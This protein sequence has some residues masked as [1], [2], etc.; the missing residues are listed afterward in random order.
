M[1]HKFIP[2]KIDLITNSLRQSK[3][4][5][6][7]NSD[8]I[9]IE[10]ESTI[11]D[12][13]NNSN[14]NSKPNN[15][16]N[17]TKTKRKR[18]SS[19]VSS[20]PNKKKKGSSKGDKN[21]SSPKKQVDDKDN[22]HLVNKGVQIN[23]NNYDDDDEEEDEDYLPVEKE[24]DSNDDGDDDEYSAAVTEEVID[25]HATIITRNHKVAELDVLTSKDDNTES[26]AVFCNQFLVSY[27]CAINKTDIIIIDDFDKENKILE[28]LNDCTNGF[29]V[30]IKFHNSLHEIKKYYSEKI[31][32]NYLRKYKNTYAYIYIYIYKFIFVY[33][34]IYICI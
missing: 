9:N 29:E 11:N 20:R 16:Y 23:I 33:I 2:L 32:I 30:M 15:D 22:G 3:L 17:N 13:N 24:S 25:D 21:K 18:N 14:K 10:H 19:E 6:K 7:N 5:L 8:Y 26:T 28:M 1:N 34:Y 4:P 27:N 12:T 31:G